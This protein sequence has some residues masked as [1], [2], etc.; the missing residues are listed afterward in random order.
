MTIDLSFTFCF[1]GA[2]RP[3]SIQIFL[4]DPKQQL[5]PHSMLIQ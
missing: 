5:Q 1:R 2:S 4:I 3:Q